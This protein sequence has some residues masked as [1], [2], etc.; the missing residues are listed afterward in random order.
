MSTFLVFT[1]SYLFS[2]SN[3]PNLLYISLAILFTC[4]SDISSHFISL[5][6]IELSPKYSSFPVS[7]FIVINILLDR[8]I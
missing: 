2:L 8:K 7:A 3:N 6:L 5:L 4:V 1:I